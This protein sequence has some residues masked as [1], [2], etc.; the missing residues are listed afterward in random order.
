MATLGKYMG[1]YMGTSTGNTMKLGTQ[2]KNAK[3][4]GVIDGSCNS[5][6]FSKP[7]RSEMRSAS[8]QHV[9]VLEVVHGQKGSCSS[10]EM[11]VFP[12]MVPQ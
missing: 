4:H 6:V 10:T 9:L 2:A 12:Q 1:K 7:V 3:Y 11:V 8:S 5:S